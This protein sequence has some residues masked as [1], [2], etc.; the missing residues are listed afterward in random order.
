M[1]DMAAGRLDLL[2]CAHH[3]HDHERRNIA[4]VGRRQQFR[5]AISQCRFTHRYLLS[6]RPVCG[7]RHRRAI[8]DGL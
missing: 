7:R 3:V 6:D 8:F 5:H 2:G 4:T 1:D